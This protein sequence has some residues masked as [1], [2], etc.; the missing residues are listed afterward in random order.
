MDKSEIYFGG[1][2]QQRIGDGLHVGGKGKK[3]NKNDS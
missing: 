1:I 3:R 2:I